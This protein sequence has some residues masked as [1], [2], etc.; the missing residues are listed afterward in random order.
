MNNYIKNLKRYTKKGDFFE[1]EWY[2]F[3]EPFNK[4]LSYKDNEEG[5]LYWLKEI[6]KYHTNEKTGSPYWVMKAGVKGI[7]PEKIDNSTSLNELVSLLGNSDLE[8]LKRENGYKDYY[9]PKNFKLEYMFKSS[10]SGTTGPAKTVYHTPQ[11]LL[12]SAVNEYTGIAAQYPVKKLKNKK[13]LSAGPVGAYQEEHKK[14]AE[15]LE[16]G[17]EGNEFETKGLKLLSINEMKKV[18]QPAME[19]ELYMLNNGNVGLATAAMEMLAMVPKD[20]FYNADLIK[21]SGTQITEERLE[22]AEKEISRKL[23]P[24]YGHYAGKS[25]IGVVDESGNITYF[26]SFPLTYINIV[27]EDKKVEYS[28]KA[29]TKMIVAEPELLV[30]SDEDYAAKD[31][32]IKAFKPVEGISDLSRN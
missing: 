14:L 32:T 22:K 1:G 10:S 20:I 25:S 29:P 6:A 30:I 3:K 11:S 4:A 13:L 28:K 15:L 21:V 23:I 17:Y 27:S 31:K 18:M 7:T 26:P 12:V 9:M 5:M 16:M 19:K 8:F 24:M 2:N